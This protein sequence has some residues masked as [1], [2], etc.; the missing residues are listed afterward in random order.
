[1]TCD[2]DHCITC[3]DAAV[4]LRVVDVRADSIAIC[5]DGSEVMLDLV[6]SVEVGDVVLV[7]AG[8]ALQRAKA[9]S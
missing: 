1:M 5:D 4:P 8:V 9:S 6:G 3:S 2:H 7:H